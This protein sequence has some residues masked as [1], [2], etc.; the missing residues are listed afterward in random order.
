[1]RGSLPRA[2]VTGIIFY[3]CLVGAAKR[4]LFLLC[5]GAIMEFSPRMGEARD[6]CSR[7]QNRHDEHRPGNRKASPF[8]PLIWTE[9]RWSAR[10]DHLDELEAQSIY[11]FREAFARLKGSR[12]CGRSA[13][14]PTS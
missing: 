7:P 3:I 12:C 2:G 11:I 5:C 10:M 4:K 6:A 1:M 8:Q 9:G 14:I 13:R